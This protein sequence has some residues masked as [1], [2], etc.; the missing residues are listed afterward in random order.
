MPSNVQLTS[1]TTLAS[2]GVAFVYLPAPA[3]SKACVVL[4]FDKNRV[5]FAEFVSD[6]PDCRSDVRPI[7]NISYPS[8]EP[9]VS[10]SVV[11]GAVGHVATRVRR[12]QLD[13]FVFTDG[14]ADV[15]PI[16]MGSAVFRS[17]NELAADDGFVGLG[18]GG[19]FASL[20]HEPETAGQNFHTA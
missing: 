20:R 10:H 11:D 9:F 6:A 15:H 14:E 19:R 13:D 3:V 5:A 4:D 7:A 16:P 17:E 12:Q 8:D 18:I 1:R 2:F